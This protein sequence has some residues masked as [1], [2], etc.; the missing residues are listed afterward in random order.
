MLLFKEKPNKSVMGLQ[1]FLGCRFAGSSP[2][3]EKEQV[4]T[5]KLSHIS[6]VVL[7]TDT[8]FHPADHYECVNCTS[9]MGCRLLGKRNSSTGAD[10]AQVFPCICRTVYMQNV[11]F[12]SRIIIFYI[13]YIIICPWIS[14]QVPLECVIKKKTP[15]IQSLQYKSFLLTDGE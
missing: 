13:I 3:D 2:H 11:C 10:T 15:G 6:S 5:K 12:G 8:W 4:A 7:R 1:A 14:L 9:K